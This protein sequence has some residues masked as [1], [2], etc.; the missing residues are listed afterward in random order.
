[1]KVG[2]YVELKKYRTTEKE[3]PDTWRIVEIKNESIVFKKKG[4]DGLFTFSKEVAIRVF[5]QHEVKGE[6]A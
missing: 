1:M 2:D 4:V 3:P 6:D 5:E